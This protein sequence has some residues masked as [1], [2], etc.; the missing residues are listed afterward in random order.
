V[1]T[2]TAT[3]EQLRDSA[4]TTKDKSSND[5]NNNSNNDNDKS[6]LPTPLASIKREQQSVND[7]KQKQEPEE[8]ATHTTK[9]TVNNHWQDINEV[10]RTDA[11]KSTEETKL[12]KLQVT[13]HKH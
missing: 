8:V 6:I 3:S 13:N 11:V 5:T 12:F 1:L 4:N 9:P 2:T 7:S 10:K